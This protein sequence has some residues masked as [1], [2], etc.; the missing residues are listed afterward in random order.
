[1]ECFGVFRLGILCLACAGMI[2]PTPL[3]SAA[4]GGETAVEQLARPIPATLDVE[5]REGGLLSGQ[6]IGSSGTPPVGTHVSV[7][8]MGM[9]VA[10]AT[11]D[12]FGNF[13]VRG[14]RAGPCEIVAGRAYG[15]FR[16][17]APNAAPP[18]ARRSALV[19]PVDGPIRGN[20]GPIGY[21]LGKPWVIA[22][23]VAIA[24]GV[25]VAIHNHRIDRISS[26]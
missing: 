26:P 19:L 1:M 14:L 13:E 5:L 11:T 4:V 24:V 25:P 16:L 2:L 10:A 8:Q 3:F 12:R 23:I 21:W 7:R 20:E 17:W 22:G 9:E 6:V 18:L 15:T